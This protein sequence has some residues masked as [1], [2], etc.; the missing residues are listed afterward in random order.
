[1]ATL[2][3]SEKP[4][5]ISEGAPKGVFYRRGARVVR[6]AATEPPGPFTRGGLTEKQLRK[7]SGT[8]VASSYSAAFVLKPGAGA[9]YTPHPGPYT[10]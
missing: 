5:V 3:R 7:V 10:P 1:M 8:P 6:G 2:A 4:G 9:V